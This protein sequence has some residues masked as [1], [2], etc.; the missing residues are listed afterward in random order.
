MVLVGEH[1]AAWPE[2]VDADVLGSHLDRIERPPVVE[3]PFAQV[4]DVEAALPLDER[5]QRGKGRLVV[6]RRDDLDR[7]PLDVSCQRLGDV[8]GIDRGDGELDALQLAGRVVD[9]VDP[10]HP[11]GAQVRLTQVD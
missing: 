4:H 7:L 1:E 2:Q 8:R 9:P 10:S 3:R 11:A 5:I 6:D